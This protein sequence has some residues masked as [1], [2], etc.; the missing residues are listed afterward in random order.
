MPYFINN[1]PFY[2]LKHISSPS[3]G[4]FND[5]TDVH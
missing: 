4:I 5:P 1:R 3:L 2:V